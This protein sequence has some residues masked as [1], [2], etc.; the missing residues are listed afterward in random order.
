M[1]MTFAA[2]I[3]LFRE[4]DLYVPAIQ[5]HEFDCKRNKGCCNFSYEKCYHLASS[6]FNK[7]KKSARN[8]ANRIGVRCDV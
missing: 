1:N 6:D 5:I 7:A 2:K 3:S 8:L 4:D